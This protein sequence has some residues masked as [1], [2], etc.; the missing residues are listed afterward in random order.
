MRKKRVGRVLIAG[1]LAAGIVVGAA[2]GTAAE[3]DSEAG[4]SPDVTIDVSLKNLRFT[5]AAIDV[6]AG[7][8]VRINVVNLDATE[9]DMLVQNLSIEKVGAATGAHHA[10]ATANMLVV[11]TVANGNGSIT[12]H[13]GEKGT[14]QF[15]CTIPGHKDAGMVGRMTVS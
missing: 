8:T 15:N 10:G 9:H 2:C 12:F 1:I 14:Y 7:K 5:P 6:P 11:H 3:S 4:G 13:T